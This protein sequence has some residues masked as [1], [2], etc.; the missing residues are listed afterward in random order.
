MET[1][2]ECKGRKAPQIKGECLAYTLLCP[3]SSFCTDRLNQR[4]WPA[5]LFKAL[6]CFFLLGASSCIHKL[7][8]KQMK[9]RR[10][11]IKISGR[12]K[13]KSKPTSLKSAANKQ[14]SGR[15]AHKSGK[16]DIKQ[17]SRQPQMKQ[18]LLN[19]QKFLMH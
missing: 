9:Q 12:G 15:L 16:T 7:M 2:A 3:C 17:C 18:L 6:S 1:V 4:E 19:M 10:N 5:V 13:K 11:Y 14:E 8:C